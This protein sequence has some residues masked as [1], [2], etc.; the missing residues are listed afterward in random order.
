MF[1]VSI[2]SSA[3]AQ[4][5]APQVRLSAPADCLQNQGC[6]IGF[7][8]IYGIDVT[9]VFTPLASA[10]AGVSA[11]D[12]GIAEVAVV[13]SSAPDLS[14]PDLTSL[15]DDRSMIGD[16]RVFAAVRATTLQ[17]EG[18]RF[19]R[20]LDRIGARLTTL[21][22]RG[23]NQQVADGRAAAVVGAEFAEAHG[24]DRATTRVTG[25]V[26]KVAFVA[27]EESE[28]LANVFAAALHG[29]GFRTK[30]RPVRGLRPEAWR[31]FRRDRFDVLPG[32]SR[33]TA[34]FLA[35]KAVRGDQANV[36]RVL[37]REA[38]KAGAWPSKLSPASDNNVFAMKRD[39]AQALG[40][41]KL[42]D[43]QRFWPRAS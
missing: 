21:K 20:P 18:A 1:C 7:K 33:S 30:V 22:L 19:L 34:S 4:S 8:A 38:R 24:F 31:Q 40:I 25:R 27:T 2:A 41:T 37:R 43:L 17:R 16:D 6:G 42:S 35:G 26:I 3:S 28:I 5:P 12:D 11:L 9:S 39:V 36:L 10:D 15:V 14:R 13:F 32:Y 23:L 29:A